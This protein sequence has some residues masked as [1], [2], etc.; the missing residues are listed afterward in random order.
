M[1]TNTTI[2]NIQP[3]PPSLISLADQIDEFKELLSD[4]Q[5]LELMD[6][7]GTLYN[8][9]KNLPTPQD[10]EEEEV[11]LSPSD[12]VLI[13][14]TSYFAKTT[15]TFLSG[16]TVIFTLEGDIVGVLRGGVIVPIEFEFE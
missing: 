4:G 13:D 15:T 11:V 8:E 7:L 5:Y 1:T 12:L 6:T 10:D 14:Q 16:E 2:Q 3:L 9:I